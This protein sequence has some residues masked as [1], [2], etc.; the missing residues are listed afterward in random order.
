MGRSPRPVSLLSNVVHATLAQR[1]VK[2]FPVRLIGDNAYESDRWM[3]IWPA[4]AW[5]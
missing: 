1:F 2:P 3:P 5:N 4:V